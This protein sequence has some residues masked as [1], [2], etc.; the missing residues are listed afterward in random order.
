MYP[1][2]TPYD[3]GL[4][5]VGEGNLVYWEV[6]GNPLGTPVVV[7]HGGP[8]SGCTAT[9]RR[10]FDPVA[11][12]IV[13]F[14]QR[15]CGRSTPHASDLRTSLTTN[16]TRH[17]V[18]DMELLREH[19]DIER[20]VVYGNSWGAT[21]ALAYAEENPDRV[22]AMVLLAVT[23][24]RPSEIAWLYHGA[25]RF[26]PEAWER[27][28]LGVPPEDRDRDLVAAYHR[29]LQS[30]DEQAAQRW[31]EWEETVAG[32]GPQ[33][34]YQDP[35]FRMA[36]ARIVTHY[37][38]NDAWLNEE[39]LLRGADRLHG[40]PGVL[41]HGRLDI[42]GPLL[43]AWELA[44]RWPD[45]ELVVVDTDGHAGEAMTTRLLAATDRLRGGS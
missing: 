44:Q 45:A 43:T 29:L 3:S 39:T 6:C 26:Y 22:S 15:Q 27:L 13:L 34:R 10:L 23:M 40:S 41:I 2:N 32:L 14:D 24:T 5:D 21:L 42:G 9:H 7:L 31:C 35:R 18:S 8:G 25:R 28:R 36:F 30:G 1:P 33:S 37:F 19:L 38:S 16:T 20:W 17:L 12:R 11:Y 4:L